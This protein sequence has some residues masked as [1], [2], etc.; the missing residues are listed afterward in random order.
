M[1]RDKFSSSKQVVSS[2]RE[3][4][5]PEHGVHENVA[6]RS[7]R[8]TRHMALDVSQLSDTAIYSYQRHTSLSHFDPL[9]PLGASIRKYTMFQ[10]IANTTPKHNEQSMFIR[11]LDG[12]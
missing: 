12:V 10:N 8:R 2:R 4:N 3:G 6:M 11:E 1:P 5:A 7:P 9:P